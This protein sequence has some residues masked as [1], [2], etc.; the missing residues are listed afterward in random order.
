MLQHASLYAQKWT[1]LLHT[2]PYLL[3]VRV[4]WLLF[5]YGSLNP[6]RIRLDEIVNKP[7]FALQIL[8]N[9]VV[10]INLWNL[11]SF[12]AEKLELLIQSSKSSLRLGLM[13]GPL[14]NIHMLVVYLPRKITLL[15]Y[16]MECYNIIQQ[17]ILT[18]VYYSIV[19]HQLPYI[20][21]STYAR[22]QTSTT[23]SQ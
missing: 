3:S 9:E 6:T 19:L 18:S 8:F 4:L 22:F 15:M 13:M 14:H 7:P 21:Y 5:R 16:A 10:L 17:N 12:N 23:S 11:T 1:I 2:F 20:Y